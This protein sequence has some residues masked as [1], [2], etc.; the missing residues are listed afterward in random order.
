MHD[1]TQPGAARAPSDAAPPDSAPARPRSLA[2]EEIGFTPQAFVR[3]FHPFELARAGVRAVLADMFGAYA[4]R[5]ELQAALH[6]RE[7]SPA[8]VYTRLDPDAP[9]SPPLERLWLDY[10]ADIGDGFNATFAVASLLGRET[11]ELA[12]ERGERFA[13]RRGSVLVM[14][15]DEVYPTASRVDYE[16]RA[17]GPY[18]AAFPYVRDARCAP[19]LFAIPGNHDWYDGL[20][21]FLRQFAQKRWVGAWK[22]RQ[23]RSY[24]VLELPHRV[25]L[26]GIDI[27]LHA[28]VDGPQLEY[29]DAAAASLAPEDRVILCTAEPSWVEVA[30]GKREGYRNLAFIEAK[31]T[32]RGARVIVVLTGDSHHYARY[33][34]AGD[35]RQYVTAGGGGAFLHG[36]HAL[37][38]EIA[39]TGF[40]GP[41]VT[42]LLSR[43]AT[44]P[45]P[46]ESLAQ[47]THLLSFSLR[48][49]AFALLWSTLWLVLGWCLFSASVAPSG[50]LD[51][52]D[53]FVGALASV[54]PTRVSLSNLPYGW[55]SLVGAVLLVIALALAARRRT[56]VLDERRDDGIDHR[57]L[58]LD[59]LLWLTLATA[60][61]LVVGLR[62]LETFLAALT[63][64][65]VAVSLVG[66]VALG[67]MVYV[68][69]ASRALRVAIGLAHAS[70]HVLL[71]LLIATCT[72]SLLAPLASSPGVLG[73]LP[74]LERLTVVIAWL[75]ISAIVA[76][77][78]SATVFGIY[79]WYAG[80]YLPEQ[81]NDA[82]SA[83]G[84][85]DYKNFI[86]LHLDA[87]GVT[88]YP[89]GIRH[90]PKAWQ[91]NP[92]SDVSASFLVPRAGASIDAE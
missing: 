11:L 64:S 89:I 2:A 17:V 22:T 59:L 79:L 10:V 80:K 83:I 90:V 68:S 46:K 82:F 8:F 19:H 67:A 34:E 81:L 91:V 58:A 57:R 51:V 6:P 16:Q 33:A 62:P 69:H 1:S 40:D 36:T 75:A 15:G 39:L 18:R 54:G 32:A 70:L 48:N 35:V 60:P 49:R 65:P 23:K 42:R 9:S 31:V 13:T 84:I 41:G 4:D 74:Q 26:W 12:G 29:F 43:R 55:V 88:A 76:G 52:G 77:L 30:A 28:D 38:H 3:W 20:S 71:W 21:A 27:Q 86:R 72:A 56:R 24:F 44:F 47:V 7:A 53:T 37:P 63:R 78:A 45:A 61:A 14:G 85:E 5:R 25:W 87:D 50:L 73:L 92:A 66:L